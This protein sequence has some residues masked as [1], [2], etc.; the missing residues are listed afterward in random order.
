[1]EILVVED[2]ILTAN[3]IRVKLEGI[4]SRVKVNC[5]S[6]LSAIEDFKSEPN[7]I[8]LD[9][10]LP[11]TNGVD[12]IKKLKQLFP[13]S[14]IIV[15]SGQNSVEVLTEAYKNGADLYMSKSE[16]SIN[17]LVEHIKNVLQRHSD[18]LNLLGAVKGLKKTLQ[19]WT[20]AK[21]IYLIDDDDIVRTMLKKAIANLNKY[22]V[23]EFD[24][25]KKCID[26]LNVPPFVVISD[27]YLKVD[28]NFNSIMEHLK[29]RD[30]WKKTKTIVY[31]AQ[32]ELP[33]AESLL[34]QGVD[35]YLFKNNSLVNDV[36]N[37]LN[38]N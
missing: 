9:H 16:N 7:V 31:S 26:G 20:S 11:G 17:Q 30:V 3:I 1:M 10:F 12:A 28:G 14:L 23:F 35:H 6:D 32:K 38:S 21:T 27:Y 34:A 5:L 13:A 19:D 29:E 33:L 25:A 2:S 4:D 37:I 24:S 18:D 22:T 15:F 8:I 36:I